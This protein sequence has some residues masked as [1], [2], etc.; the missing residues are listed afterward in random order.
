IIV[1]RHQ[2]QSPLAA[3]QQPGC[4]KILTRK[5][6]VGVLSAARLLEAWLKAGLLEARSTGNAWPRLLRLSGGCSRA[7]GLA[8][9]GRHRS[10]RLVRRKPPAHA[11]ET[12]L[13]RPLQPWCE[14]DRSDVVAVDFCTPPFRL[15]HDHVEGHGSGEG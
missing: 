8:R 4:E 5:P 13:G 12:R 14:E 1:A 10:P 9:S 11:V 3:P 6:N 7:G 2:Q 15:N